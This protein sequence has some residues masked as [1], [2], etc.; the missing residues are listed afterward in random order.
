MHACYRYAI[1]R[2][3]EYLV[4]TGAGIDDIKVCKK[5]FVWPLQRVRFNQRSAKSIADMFM[6][7]VRGYL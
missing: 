2:P 5:A 1:S 7:S 4:L 6:N 3:S